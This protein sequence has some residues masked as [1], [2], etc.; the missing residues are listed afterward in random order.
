[1]P[2]EIP[3]SNHRRT[4]ALVAAAAAALL[5][6]GSLLGGVLG[7][8]RTAE[9]APSSSPRLEVDAALPLGGTA[10]AVTRLERAVQ[11]DPRD[12][13]RLGELG[14]AYQLR[15][16]ETG[17]PSF[18]PLSERAL[19]EALDARPRD[20]AATIGLGNLALIRHDFRG[21][22]ELGRE[23]RRRAPFAARPYGVVGDAL[24]E[25]G[26]YRQAFAA[27]D[28]MA[29]VRPSL[30]S[31]AR[32]AYARE[33]TGDRR[34]AIS[35]MTLALDAAGGVPE[36][37][38][39]A[40]VE[41][42]KLALGDGRVDAA[43]DHG[44]AALAIFPGYVLALEQQ[45]RI[46]AARGNLGAAVATARRAATAVP[47]PQFVALLGDLLDRQGRTAAAVRQRSTVA[48]ID[49][50]LNANG[51]RVDLETAV[52]QADH[53]IRPAE[54]VRLA[55]RARAERPSIYGDDALGW[56]L[57][58]AGRCAEAEPWL[59]RALRLGTKDAL[60]YF[61]RGYATGCAGDRDAMRVWYRRALEQS[62][63][64]SVRWA[65]VAAKALP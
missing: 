21:A 4:I 57:A 10:V 32:V 26:R 49:R 59:D 28:R 29:A 27:F 16:R 35:A 45:A 50:V 30:A 22:L 41:L 34:G 64:F 47:L 65:P 9:G 20:A 56:A 19:R 11:D 51:L 44:R 2:P 15:W 53:R 3:S 6:V 1:M 38:A 25:L 40:H 54:T 60:L 42:A 48:A 13:D 12:A 46:E 61:H 5:V 37:T 55:R 17:D 14:L 36:P 24:I 62:P 31:Y 52:F 7:E 18:L 23:A 8:L 63:A 43:A 39:W 33:L 58:R